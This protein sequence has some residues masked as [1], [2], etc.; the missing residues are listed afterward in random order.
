[1]SFELVIQLFSAS[2]VV[3]SNN[4]RLYP[5]TIVGDFNG[6]KFGFVSSALPKRNFFFLLLRKPGV[7]ETVSDSQISIY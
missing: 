5:Q 1:M 7:E 6:E 4:L 3:C 2:K